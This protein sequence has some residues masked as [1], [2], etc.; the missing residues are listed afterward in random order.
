MVMTAGGVSKQK[1]ATV[2]VA[3]DGSGDTDDIQTGIN[4]LPASGG[5]VYVKEGDY[6]ITSQIEITI[7]N[8]SVKGSGKS[9]RIFRSINPEIIGLTGVDFIEIDSIFFQS[10]ANSTLNQSAI[11]MN[12]CN[13]VKVRGCWFDTELDNG[14]RV[15]AS[16][17]D[18]L[19]D[20]NSFF[21]DT[22]YGVKVEDSTVVNIVNNSFTDIA[23]NACYIHDCTHSIIANNILDGIVSFGIW[24]NTSDYCIFSGNVIKNGTNAGIHV[25]NASLRNLINNNMIIGNGGYG[26]RINDGSNVNNLINGNVVYNN[27]SGNISD[28]GT[29]SIVTDNIVT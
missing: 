4:M 27:T 14:I 24:C 21:G 13:T 8:V 9:T 25:D 5:V 18:I 7:D 23:T 19:I 28:L 12:G 6:T 26:I 3:A 10:T 16:C 29:G 11:L 22:N 20:G 2:I 15:R 1:V 17:H